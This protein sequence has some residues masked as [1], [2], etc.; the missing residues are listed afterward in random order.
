MHEP[1]KESSWTE[2][3]QHSQEPGFLLGTDLTR[4]NMHRREILCPPVSKPLKAL[5]ESHLPRG[6]SSELKPI[7][8]LKSV[9]RAGPKQ[10][11]FILIV[12]KQGGPL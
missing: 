5:F 12:P 7:E 2:S 9:C 8:L 4:S 3:S 1:R 6:I 11:V 10:T